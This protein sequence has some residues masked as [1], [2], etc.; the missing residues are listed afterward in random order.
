MSIDFMKMKILDSLI[1][2][3]NKEEQFFK[4]KAYRCEKCPSRFKEERTMT[5]R[6]VCNPRHHV[7]A[8]QL[9]PR[10]YSVFHL[11]CRFCQKRFNNSGYCHDSKDC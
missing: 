9:L 7:R 2:V 4:K 6:A 3:T 11:S 5:N 10:N 8:N 1:N